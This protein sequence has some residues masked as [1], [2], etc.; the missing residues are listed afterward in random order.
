M[1][2]SSLFVGLEVSHHYDSLVSVDVYGSDRQ[3]ALARL[4]RRYEPD[5]GVK[6]TLPF[7]RRPWMTALHRR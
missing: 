5:L 3:Q 1:V 4:R 7:H 2:D 6:T